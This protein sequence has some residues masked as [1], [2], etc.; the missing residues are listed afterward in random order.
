MILLALLLMAPDWKP[1]P[2]PPPGNDISCSQ[3]QVVRTEKALS[4]EFADALRRMANC[5]PKNAVACHDRPRAMRLVRA[6]QGAWIT[7]RNTHCDVMAFSVS[8]TSAESVL[9][10]DCR[11]ELSEGR[12]AELK[13]IGR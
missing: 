7:W 9:R 4:R 10:N 2:C 1:D 8:G 3:S 5:R 11:S 12:I 6:E 13:Q